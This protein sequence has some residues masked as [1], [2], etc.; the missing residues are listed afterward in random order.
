MGAATSVVLKRNERQLSLTCGGAVQSALPLSSLVVQRRYAGDPTEYLTE[1]L[2][3][4]VADESAD[5]CQSKIPAHQE[6]F[7]L[8]NSHMHQVVGEGHPHFFFE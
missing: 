1:V 8:R 6:L 2:G 3:V 7:G 4:I 5:I